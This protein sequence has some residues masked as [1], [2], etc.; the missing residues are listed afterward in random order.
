V[1]DH[2]LCVF[3]QDIVCGLFVCLSFFSLHEPIGSLHFRSYLMPFI[4]FFFFTTLLKCRSGAVLREVQRKTL[5]E[6][7][8]E[9]LPIDTIR[10]SSK[11]T[12]IRTQGQEGS[13]IALIDMEDG[14]TIRAKVTCH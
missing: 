12:S 13:S 14:T 11:L 1:Q 10:F 4:L 2:I 6:A 5:L 3:L 8:A 7:L 9:E